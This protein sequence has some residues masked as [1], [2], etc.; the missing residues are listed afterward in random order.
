MVKFLLIWYDK[1]DFL[2]EFEIWTW[3]KPWNTSLWRVSVLAIGAL[4]ACSSS[5]EKKTEKIKMEV[6]TVGTAKPFSYEDKDGK[7]TGY[8]IEVLRAILKDSDSMKSISN[9]TKW[10]SSD[11][12]GDRYQIG[13]N[14][15]SYSRRTG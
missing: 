4:V 2:G 1:E 5:S 11:L 14:N 9:K 10:A 15:I 6:R 3:R 12:D 8:D 7:L 13:A